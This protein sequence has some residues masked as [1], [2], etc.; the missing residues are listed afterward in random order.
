M[1]EK[2]VANLVKTVLVCV[3]CFM[4]SYA[5]FKFAFGYVGGFLIRLLAGAA[6]SVVSS[7]IFSK[8][9]RDLFDKYAK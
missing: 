9:I 5:S 7:F 4:A 8:L 1:K 3:V 2:D 6:L